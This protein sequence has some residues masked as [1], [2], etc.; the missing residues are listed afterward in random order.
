MS[1]FQDGRMKGEGVRN[2]P[3][4]QAPAKLQARTSL[5]LWSAGQW[6]NAQNQYVLLSNAL[7]GIPCEFWT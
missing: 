5:S 4:T 1:G 3:K 2:S 7:L 6:A